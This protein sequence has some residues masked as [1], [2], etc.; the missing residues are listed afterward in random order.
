MNPFGLAKDKKLF[1]FVWTPAQARRYSLTA[2]AVDD[3]GQAAT[4]APVALLIFV[5]DSVPPTIQ[6]TNAPPDF[7]RLTSPLIELAGTA[8]DD[9][10]LDHVEYARW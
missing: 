4:A 5:P 6:I 7:A 1:E 2:L 9:I 8:K 10:G 3:L